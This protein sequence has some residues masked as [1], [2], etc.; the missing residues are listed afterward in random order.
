MFLT[1][2][3]GSMISYEPHGHCVLKSTPYSSCLHAAYMCHLCD[4]W[5]NI[6]RTVLFYGIGL[7]YVRLYTWALLWQKHWPDHQI[8]QCYLLLYITFISDFLNFW[9]N[10]TCK[11]ARSTTVLW[12]TAIVSETETEIHTGDVETRDLRNWIT[13][14]TP[15]D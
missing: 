6:H 15:S 7:F 12:I 9:L 10:L 1:W 2:Q 14:L 13:F 4:N 8:Y 3:T 5:L 11:I